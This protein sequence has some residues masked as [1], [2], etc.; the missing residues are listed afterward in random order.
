MN[1]YEASIPRAF[2]AL[3]SIAMTALVL[4]VT[5]VLPATSTSGVERILVVGEPIR[6]EPVVHTS[7]T[8][9]AN[10]GCRPTPAAASA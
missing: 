4:G 3:A 8:P 5:V 1:R 10:V 7:G 9:P 6:G 2:C